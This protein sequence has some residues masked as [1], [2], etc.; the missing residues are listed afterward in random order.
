MARDGGEALEATRSCGPGRRMGYGGTTGSAVWKV[1]EGTGVQG[2][3]A[4]PVGEERGRLRVGS[5]DPGEVGLS[6]F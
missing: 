4:R 6:R 3:D 2:S 1:D 5:S